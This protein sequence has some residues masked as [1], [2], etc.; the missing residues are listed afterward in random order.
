MKKIKTLFC[1]NYETDR[2]VRDELVPGTEWVVAGEGVALRKY[3]GTCCLIKDGKFYKR[4]EL[5]AGKTRKKRDPGRCYRKA[6]LIPVGYTKGG[7]VALQLRPE[8]IPAPE[9]PNG[10][11]LSLI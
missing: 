6:G 5:K 8:D 3:D 10:M 7:L 11:Q 1:R 9:C 2:L 4:Y